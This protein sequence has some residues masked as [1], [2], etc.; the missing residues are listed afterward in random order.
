MRK[1]DDPAPITIDA[2]RA[3]DAGTAERRIPST[4]SLDF[5]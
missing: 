4:S 3:V 1:L 2:R 5:R